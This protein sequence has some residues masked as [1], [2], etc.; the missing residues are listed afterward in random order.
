MASEESIRGCYQAAT[1]F[2][3]H[4]SVFGRA[5]AGFALSSLRLHIAGTRRGVIYLFD[6]CPA[7]WHVPLI[8]GHCVLAAAGLLVSAAQNSLKDS[9]AGTL[10]TLLHSL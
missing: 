9:S 4:L 6:Y 8:D 7:S 5:A 1:T 2:L 3:L 10:V